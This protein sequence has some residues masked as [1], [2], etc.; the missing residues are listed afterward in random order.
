M[1]AIG[2]IYTRVKLWSDDAQLTLKLVSIMMMIFLQF[3]TDH[4]GLH[5]CDILNG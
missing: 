5:M 4:N 2:G 1:M 3:T